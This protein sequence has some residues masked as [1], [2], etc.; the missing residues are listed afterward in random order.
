VIICGILLTV[1]CSRQTY[2]K[3]AVQLCV[4]P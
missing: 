3:W 4:A 2:S 1:S